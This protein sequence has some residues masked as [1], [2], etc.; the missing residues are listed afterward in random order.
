MDLKQLL[1][2]EGKLERE[3]LE[4]TAVGLSKTEK[5]EIY[6]IIEIIKEC[7]NEKDNRSGDAEREQEANQ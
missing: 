1:Y 4:R 5:D 2:Q 3:Y 6:R 7:V